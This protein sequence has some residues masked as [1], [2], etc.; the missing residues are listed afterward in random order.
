MENQNHLGNQKDAKKN[1]QDQISRVPQNDWSQKNE[2]HHEQS[3]QIDNSNQNQGAN[4]LDGPSRQDRNEDQSYQNGVPDRRSGNDD[5]VE[6][7]AEG[8]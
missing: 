2:P 7:L 5:D 6:S 4:A 1:Q 8:K 3:H